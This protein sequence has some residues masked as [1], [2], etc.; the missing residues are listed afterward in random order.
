VPDVAQARTCAWNGIQFSKDRSATVVAFRPGGNAVELRPDAS[1]RR[2][3]SVS[4]AKALKYTKSLASPARL[5]VSF[6]TRSHC[7]ENGLTHA[8][9]HERRRE[10][11]ESSAF[12]SRRR[13]GSASYM[14]TDTCRCVCCSNLCSA[15]TGVGGAH[16]QHGPVA[17]L[18]KDSKRARS[19]VEGV[20]DDTHLKHSQRLSALQDAESAESEE[21]AVARGTDS[22]ARS[23]RWLTPSRRASRLWLGRRGASAVCE[24]YRASVL[25]LATRASS[26]FFSSPQRERRRR[27]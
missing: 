9:T 14:S 18:R 8:R 5:A 3:H 2:A 12:R 1:N 21:T 10:E 16:L 7:G 22:E 23:R 15:H 27:V 4:L 17:H 26:L 20:V 6:R 24:R 19:S 25:D 13:L 11:R